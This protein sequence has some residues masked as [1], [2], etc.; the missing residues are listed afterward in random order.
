MI[1]LVLIMCVMYEIEVC[2]E[3]EKFLKLLLL[4]W[5]VMENKDVNVI[6]R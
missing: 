1:F 2:N 6:M 3:F 5:K 4:L